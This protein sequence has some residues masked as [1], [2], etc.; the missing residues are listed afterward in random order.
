MKDPNNVERRQFLQQAGVITLAGVLGCDSGQNSDALTGPDASILPTDTSASDVEIADDLGRNKDVTERADVGLEPVDT[1]P[2]N[3]PE[4]EYEGLLGPATLFSHGVASGDPLSSAVILWTRVSTES[5]VSVD[6]WWE[7]SLT[8]DFSWRVAI[9]T[10]T[11][12]SE[13][14]FTV[15]VDADGLSPSTT[16]YYR[17]FALG[18]ES[19]T[20]RTRTAPTGTCE[21]LRLAVASCS[22]YS[23][24]YFS[25]YRHIGER[26]DLDAVLHLGDYM[27]EYKGGNSLGRQHLPA[28]EVLTLADYRERY[29]QYRSDPDLQEAHRQHPFIMVWD[30]HETA[31]NAWKGGAVNHNPNT[32]GD[33]EVRK[34]ASIQAYHEWQPIREQ[35]DLRIFRQFQF[36]DLVDLTMLDTR[37]FG[38]TEQVEIADITRVIDPANT[39]LGAEQESWLAERMLESTARWRFIGQ[40]VIMF[41]L[42]AAGQIINDD[43]WDAYQASRDRLFDVLDEGAADNVVV[44]TGDFHSSWAAECPRTAAEYVVGENAYAVE[45]VTPGITSGF[46]YDPVLADLAIEFNPHI[47]YGE[48]SSKGYMVLDITQARAQAAWFYMDTV[49][50][51][52]SAQSFGAAYSVSHGSTKL[53]E[54]SE[55]VAE[56]EGPPLAP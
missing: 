26:T 48:V 7:I 11:A 19:V 14:D 46:N 47:A 23:R 50:S 42:Q 18:R 54:D 28:R 17:F 1:G 29:A 25:A 5:D 31:N 30:D 21:H 49:T 41:P 34:A 36:G 10:V 9:G 32:E 56:S 16:Y 44:L 33:W 13:R 27:Y 43:Q 4:Y 38:R 37:L 20:G 12:S 3:L 22:N 40:Q 8:A 55:P 45:F 2:P 52:N 51:P 24:G 35:P 53:T 39:I 6:V 15:K